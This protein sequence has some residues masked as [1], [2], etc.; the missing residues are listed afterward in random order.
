MNYF[1]T[2]AASDN[3]G[4]AG[5]QQDVKVAHDLGCW[6][7]SAITGITVQNFENVFKVEPVNPLL[8]HSQIQQCCDSFSV[9]SVK[10]GAICSGENIRVIAECLRKYAIPWVVL[11]PVL[12]STSGKSFLDETSLLF[13]KETLF[14]LTD[15]ITPNKP[16][17]EILTG[18][19]FTTIEEGIEI[20]MSKCIEW[21]T[22][23]LLKGGH[24]DD[25]N[26]KEAII[27]KTHV[28]RFERERKTFSYNHGTGCTLSTA[29]ACFLGANKSLSQAYSLASEYLMEYYSSKQIQE[30]PFMDDE[31]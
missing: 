3:S 1:L 15:L 28:Y 7:L 12:S 10:I 26:I 25:A 5:I 24:F 22:S 9:K 13:L 27:T 11:D 30:T 17:F 4:G 23:I 8:L 21:N 20:A 16:E 2:I 29:M 14:P 6:A 31:E 19:R 18:S